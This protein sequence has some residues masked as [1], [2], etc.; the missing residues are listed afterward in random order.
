MAE[1]S[2]PWSGIGTWALEAERAEAEERERAAAD[3]ST[4][5]P[6]FLADESMQGFPS[7]KE[8][9]RKPKKKKGVSLTLSEFTSGTYVGPGGARRKPTFDSNG[10]TVEE[11]TRLP[12]GPRQR[13]VDELDHSRLGGG[14]RSNG[15]GG[16][17]PPRYLSEEFT[18]VSDRDHPSRSDEV[19]NWAHFKKPFAMDS[20]RQDR[21]G[22]LGASKADEDDNWSLG[23]KSVAPPSRHSGFGSGFRDSFGSGM[24][25]DRWDRGSVHLPRNGERER[26]RL[27]LDPPKTD[28]E[29]QP[30]PTRSRPSP[31]AAARPREE[32][33]AEKGLDWKKMEIE[34]EMKKTSGFTDSY[35]SRTSSAQSSRPGSSGSQASEEGGVPKLRP[36]VNPFGDAKPREVLLEE[37]GMDWRKIDQELE[38]RGIERP[39][40]EEEKK[41]KEEIDNLKKELAKETGSNV[42]GDSSHLPTEQSDSLLEQIRKREK[43]LENLIR[44]LD[45]KVRFGQRA[46]AN[47]RPGSGSRRTPFSAEKPSVQTGFSED[48]RQTEFV[49]RPRSRGTGD[50]WYR[51]VIEKR[52]FQSNRDSTLLPSRSMD[53]SKSGERW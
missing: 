32:V 16:V 37:K 43:E 41:L 52:G 46:F 2:K 12:T 11:M 28:S 34:I 15:Y 8:G 10:L 39:E 42:N 4:A 30:E 40:T 44:E 9:A 23:K 38:H 29:A 50:S 20:R 18:K 1:V 45:D 21:Y 13:T 35:S 51:P 33:L 31:F 47:A 6:T 27:V 17:A 26:P 3:S 48:S 24:H 53:R 22:S 36:K 5:R 49:E 25:S 14:F 7:L 19:D